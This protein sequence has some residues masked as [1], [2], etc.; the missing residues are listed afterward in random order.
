M[1]KKFFSITGNVVISFEMIFSSDKNHM[2]FGAITCAMG[3]RYKSYCSNLV[4]TLMVDP[5][6]EMQ[7]NYNFLLQ[8]EEELLKHLKHGQFR[9]R[10]CGKSLTWAGLK[11]SLFHTGVKICDAYNAALEYVK[12]E[13]ADLVAKLTKNLG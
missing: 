11:P 13:K 10:Q 9:P 2:H 3:I 12:K 6:Q 4:R 1:P 8:V 7:D 5:T